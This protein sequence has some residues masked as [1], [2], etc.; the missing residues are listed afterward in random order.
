M[1]ESNSSYFINLLD[2]PVYAIKWPSICDVVH[3]NNTLQADRQ[4]NTLQADRQT[5][6]VA[7]LHAKHSCVTD[8]LT[9]LLSYDNLGSNTN[10][11]AIW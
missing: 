4:N 5:C 7:K 1:K 2:P 9:A 6:Q 10:T 11:N 8:L 3:Q